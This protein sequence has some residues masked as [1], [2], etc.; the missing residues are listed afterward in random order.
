MHFKAPLIAGLA[1]LS[2]AL[3]TS[4]QPSKTSRSSPTLSTS[5]GF[6]IRLS[7]TDPSNNA[8]L[9]VSGQYLSGARVGAGSYISVL[10]AAPGQAYYLNGTEP[11]TGTA[12]QDIVGVYPISISIADADTFDFSYPEE[13]DV[14]EDIG[15]NSLFTVSEGNN[16]VL[17]GAG[18]AAGGQFAAC[19][20][21]FVFYG[22]ETT[23]LTLRYVYGGEIV[24]MDCVP[25]E[26]G[27]EC[28]TLEDLPADAAWDHV[29]AQEVSCLLY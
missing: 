27:L 24:P 17:V 12:T 11:G 10:S 22:D 3:S 2:T 14:G 20:R 19:E 15:A 26:L 4:N 21:D 25:V 23:I 5:K 13:H 7:V 29:S 6:S 28:A 1:G 18:D 8:G 16:P 9:D